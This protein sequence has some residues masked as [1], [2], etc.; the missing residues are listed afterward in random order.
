MNTPE[1]DAELAAIPDL[2]KAH[3]NILTRRAYDLEELTTVPGKREPDHVVAVFFNPKNGRRVR[4]A[5][6][7]ASSDI[8]RALVVS[9]TADGEGQFLLSHYLKKHGREDLDVWLH[10]EANN[11]NIRVYWDDFFKK[12]DTLFNTLLKDIVEGR[13]WEEVLFDWGDYK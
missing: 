5:C 2:I 4:I 9:F 10:A 13:S 8:R 7:P 12:L 1:S 3:A 11:P 6:F